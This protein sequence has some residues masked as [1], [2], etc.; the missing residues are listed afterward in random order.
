MSDVFELQDRI[1]ESVVAAIEPNVQLAE[2]ERMKHKPVAN[3]DA[4]DLLLRAQ[5]LEYEFTQESLDEA[6]RCLE[7]ALTLDP[8][9]A[10]AMA[11]AAYCYAWR[12]PQGWARDSAMEATE[13]VRLASRA[14]ELAKD[15]ANVLWMAAYAIWQ[16]A[17]DTQHAKQLAY[18]SLAINP[19]SAIALTTAAYIEINSGNIAKALEYARH[20]ER[21]NPRDPRG[22]A[23]LTVLAFAHLLEDRFEEAATTAKQALV[24]NSRYAVTLRIL[25]ASLAKLGQRAEAADVVRQILIIEP[26]LTLSK[27]RARSMFIDDSVWN[28]YAEGLRLAGIPE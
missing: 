23:N 11:L 1:T 26:Q 18:R 20:A 27:Q 4:Y 14:V 2:I 28:R 12:R 5:Q 3:L 10:P 6:L 25:A 24:L 13:G 15:D 17:M 9:Y 8:S 16:L 21:L 19:N 7:K 22:W